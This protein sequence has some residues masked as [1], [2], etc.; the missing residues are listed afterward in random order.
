MHDIFLSYSRKDNQTMQQVK[1]TLLDAGFTVW[2]DEGIEAGT[3]SWKDAID[4]AIHECSA[5]VCILSPDAKKSKWV[6]AELDRAE[7]YDRKIFLILARGTKREAIPFGYDSHQYTDIRQPDD[8]STKMKLL[9]RSMRAHIPEPIPEKEEAIAGKGV[10]GADEQLPPTLD[11]IKFLMPAP[12]DWCYIPAGEVTIEAG[13]YVPEGGKT[14][15]V[16]AFYMAKYPVT[17]RQFAEFIGAG[18]YRTQSYWTEE[19]W[20][21][22]QKNK[23]TQPRYFHDTK[24]NRPTHPVVGVTWFEALAFCNW[25]NTKNPEDEP[26]TE[27]NI[28]LP[29]EQQWQRAAQ[30]DDGRLFPWGN[31][32]DDSLANTRTSK[33]NRTTS[34][35]QY[36]QSVSPYDVVDLSGNVWEWCL[37]D[38]GLVDESDNYRLVLR[39]GSWRDEFSSASIRYRNDNFSK[40]FRINAIGFRICAVPTQSE[41]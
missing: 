29:T 23:W 4:T 12:F 16:D 6:K 8:Y 27:I 32:F 18:G 36:P 3:P 37:T 26:S 30:G 40:D 22:C 19:G 20:K 1:Q 38:Y 17:N 7:T 35:K 34:V 13:G 5:L 25:L 39:G 41:L 9:V 33:I 21:L 2:T 31:R 10:A 28:T 11:A 24:W 15:P 14:Y